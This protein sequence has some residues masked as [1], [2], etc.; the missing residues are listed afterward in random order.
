MQKLQLQNDV[1]C[2]FFGRP[3]SRSQPVDACPDFNRDR[4]LQGSQHADGYWRRR[5]LAPHKQS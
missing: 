4:P 1:T 3:W 2:Q 5:A